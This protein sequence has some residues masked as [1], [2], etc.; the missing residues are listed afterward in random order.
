MNKFFKYTLCAAVAVLMSVGFNSCINDLDVEPIDPALQSD[1]TPEQL[2]NKCYSVFATSGNNGGDDNVDIDGLDGGFQ[3]K[4]RQMWNSNELTTDEAICGWGD[5]GIASFCHNSYDASHPMLRGYYYG[6]C[7]GITFCNHYID[8]YGDYDATMTAE[9]RFLR[10]FQ[11]LL[12][13][14]AFGNV[15]FTT[16]ISGDNPEQYSRAQV[17]EF[18]ESELKDIVGETSSD[19]VL[20]DP[21][22]KNY[23]QQGFGRV[24]KAAGWMLLSRL[25]LNSQVYT[26]KARWAEARDYAK[27]VMD[28]SYK[29][30]TN[31]YN[32]TGAD[33]ITRHW[34][35]YQMLFMGDNGTNGAMVEAVF[36]VIQYGTRTTSWGGTNFLICSTFDGDMHAN[37][38]DPTEV[39]GL[40]NN[41]T[42]GGNRARPEL[43]KKFFSDI[44]APE[45]P[46]YD[47][48]VAAGDDRALFDTQGRN[49][50][51]E[52]ESDFK[53]GYAIAKFTN[54][55]CDGSKGSDITFADSQL[56]YMRAAEAYLTYAEAVTRLGGTGAAPADAVQ[57]INALR[58]RAHATTKASY[59]LN[60]ILDEW[61]RE[62]Y[63]EGRRRVDL[64]RFGKFGGSTDYKWQWKGG[65]YAGRDFEAYRNVFA[66]PTDDLIANSNLKQNEGYK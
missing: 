16:S 62:F 36:P 53:Y 10:A 55:K 13:T 3:H 8:V 14:D 48:Y 22:P 49:L 35:A 29:L 58:A 34:T 63:F 4:F 21:S 64:I 2:F 47:V 12:L 46:A 32:G 9:I 60:D 40:Y 41:N 56:M 57:A 61:S 66:I 20:S 39:N 37:P 44:E 33:G 27:K 50:N 43:I 25:Y 26:G 23:G 24:D 45:G 18:V 51:V 19:Q 15:P 38:Y 52:N 11:F 7:I 17:C 59:S 28:S 5:D 65:A 6:L 54:F 1:V 30:F 42:W 31:D